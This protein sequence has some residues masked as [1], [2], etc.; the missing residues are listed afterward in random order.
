MHL[1]HIPQCNTLEQKCEMCTFLF[2]CGA[3]SVMGQMHGWI[4]GIVLVCF[5]SIE[6]Y[7]LVYISI[8]NPYIQWG[9]CTLYQLLEVYYVVPFS[10][11]LFFFWS[12]NSFQNLLTVLGSWDRYCLVE[13]AVQW[14]GQAVF[15]TIRIMISIN[16]EHLTKTCAD[17]IVRQVWYH[18]S[19]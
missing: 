10:E 1:D 14:Q 8:Y 7:M 19:G 4:C 2:Q 11:H 9:T 6:H 12:S 13:R 3:L 16:S 15:E 17:W 5:N 18:R